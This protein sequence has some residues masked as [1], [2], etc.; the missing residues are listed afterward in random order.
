MKKAAIISIGTEIMR[1]KM[2]DTNSTYLSRFLTKAGIMVSWRLSVEDDVD[3]IIK[4]LTFVESCDLVILT[5]G[6]GPT[7]DDCTRAALAKYAGKE[8]VFSEDIW[9]TIKAFFAK[10]QWNIPDSNK[11]QAMIFDGA[12]PIENVA[13]TAPG[14]FYANNDRLFF[15]LPGPPPENQIMINNQLLTKLQEHKFIESTIHTKVIRVYNVGEGTIADLIAPLDLSSSIGYYFTRYGWI[16][17]HVTVFSDDLIAQQQKDLDL[18]ITTLKTK[19]SFTTHNENLDKILLDMLK[20]KKQTISFAESITGGH[21]AAQLVR[22]S[23]ASTVFPGGF[24]TYS[25]Q[26][27]HDLLGVKEETLT[28]YGAVSE[29]TAREMALGLKNRTNTD[30]CAIVTGIAGPDG[31][32]AEKPVGL[33][34]F[35]FC[36]GDKVT[37]IKEVFTGNRERIIRRTINKVYLETLKYLGYTNT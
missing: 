4:A 12:E 18:I 35:G 3:E 24:V 8:L 27:K 31:G 20:E 29:Q 17:I 21:I 1:G 30:I 22:N 34:Y 16:E 19:N 15:L 33:V 7:E 6:L 13:G 5:G 32:S 23:G 11:R 36:F 28:T 14:L 10:R 25:N 2:D 37:V 9:Q 26:L